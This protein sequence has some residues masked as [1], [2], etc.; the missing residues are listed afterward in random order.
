MA[1]A[2]K[3][4]TIAENEPKVFKAGKQSEYDRFWDK[5]LNSVNFAF[6]FAGYGWTEE[7]LVP[8]RD[9]VPQNAW[10]MFANSNKIPADLEQHFKNI[11]KKLDFSQC[12]N[13]TY[14]FYGNSAIKVI[15]EID[16]RSCDNL[17]NTFYGANQLITIRNLI[18]KDDGSQLFY[19]GTFNN[20]IALENLT[21]NGKIGQDKF[22]VSPCTLLTHE[23][24]MSIINALYDYSDTTT[25]KTVTIGA[26]NLAKLTDAEKKTATDKG[27][28]LV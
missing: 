19:N 3:L 28:S 8:P 4:K 2:D 25:T 27:W 11:G 21:I 26:E 16:T 9:I 17:Q 18:L 13:F 14:T 24:L 12:K 22:D 10:Y 7:T 23:S 6:R 5:Y 1:I 15:G 20:C